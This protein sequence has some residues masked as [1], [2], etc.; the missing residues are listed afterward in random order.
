MKHL[1]MG[2]AGHVDHGK[3]ALIKALTGID[4]DTHPEEKKRGI[5]MNLGF[6]YLELPFGDKVGIVDVPGHRDF[7]HTMVGGAFGVDF[8]LLVIAADSG[9]M[10]QTR[11]HVQIMEVLGIKKGIVVLNKIDLVEEELREISRQEVEDFLK[12][13]FL[14]SAPIV[15]VSAKTGEGI[16]ALKETI[17]QVCETVDERSKG[18]IF[19]LYVDRVF[20]VAGF[21]TV[22]TGTVMG[23]V[24]KENDKAYLLPDFN[25]ELRIRR[26]ERHGEQV[27]E[28]IGGDRASI[29]LVGLD[30]SDFSRGMLVSD[31]L[32]EPTQRIDVKLSV[33]E[34]VTSLDL[35]SQ[36]VLHCGTNEIQAR[37]HLLDKI[38]LKGGENAVAQIILSKP[39]VI[40]NEDRF[41]I[42][43]TSSDLTLGGGVVIDAHPLHHRRRT[44]KMIKEVNK[45]AS[46][47]LAE[48]IV[49]EVSKRYRIVDAQEIADGLN[50]SKEEIL[51]V[52][53]SGLS[54]DVCVLSENGETIL[55][56]KPEAQRIRERM[57]KRIQGFHRRNPY[58]E[59]GMILDAFLSI[60]SFEI[61]SPGEL[62]LKHLLKSL[63]EEKIVE[64]RAN[65]WALEAH[66]VEVDNR[67]QKQINFLL[68]YLQKCGFKTPLRSEF[69]LD[70]KRQAGINENELKQILYYLLK[71]QKIYE[72]EEN[73]IHGD[74]VDQSRD[75]LLKAL[76]EKEE[77]LRVADFRDLIGGNRK[78]CLLL[79]GQYDRE[80]II[81]RK[82]DF[83]VLTEKGKGLIK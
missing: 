18:E 2:T 79:L 16:V 40:F 31:R 12:D 63:E 4:C 33:F 75:S 24:L 56:L 57:I 17:R 14:K 20:S 52:I 35:W 67:M 38:K 68:D 83:R 49:A 74:I 21:G 65:T 46:G 32:L 29:N 73:F 10:P 55:L 8:V 11:E 50:I 27:K 72:I 34:K 47:D 26:M 64:K 78:I 80:G 15:E 28:I 41:V 19:R 42:R 81:E 30:R 43:N 69:I 22:V 66:K 25:K 44:E 6:S 61:G 60:F 70:A 58:E 39:A 62:F 54:E 51:K 37:V 36:V 77:G 1:I 3:T 5:T 71:Q 76:M 23:G 7:V 59:K 13:T 53:E 9:V 48:L 82:G 45:V